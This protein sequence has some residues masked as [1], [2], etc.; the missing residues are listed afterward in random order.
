MTERSPYRP[1]TAR[2]IAERIRIRAGAFAMP[3]LLGRPSALSVVDH[4]SD[5]AVSLTTYGRR[6]EQV[7]LTIESIAR[8]C[9]RPGRLVLWMDEEDWRRPPD[10]LRRLADRGLE[11]RRTRAEWGPHKKYFPYCL[12]HADDGQLLVTAD[13]DV[14]YPE[15]WL[16][17]LVH[18]A[19]QDPGVVSAHRARR[20]EVRDGMLASYQT[21][22]LARSSTP[23]RRHLAVGMG[24]VAYPP[25]FQRVMRDAGEAFLELAP[26]TDDLWLHV[27]QLR[28]GFRIAQVHDRPVDFALQRGSQQVALALANQLGDE[29]D[30]VV[31]ALYT[32]DDV[33]ELEGSRD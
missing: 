12:E 13:D 5:V 26:R 31:R 2:E 17:D 25:P 32:A 21:W 8:G 20:I 22:A 9:M 6:V 1:R 29:N 15:R 24:G 23:S 10:A 3:I 19:S 28:T 27:H 18:A 7:H 33:A 30:Q 14:F 11:L 16:D 4:A